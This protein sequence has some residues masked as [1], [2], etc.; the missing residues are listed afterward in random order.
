M[1]RFSDQ[2][3]PGAVSSPGDEIWKKVKAAEAAF[4]S[5]KPHAKR[6]ANLKTR[7]VD[8]VLGSKYRKST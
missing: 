3:S 5:E 6:T 7:R 4:S 8:E 1:N 2:Y